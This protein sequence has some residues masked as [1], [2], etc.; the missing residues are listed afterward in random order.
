VGGRQLQQKNFVQRLKHL[1]AAHPSVPPSWLE[2]E[3]L[4]TSALEDIAQV[5]HVIESCRDIGVA[6]SIDDFGTGYSS[7][8]Y[9]RRLPVSLLKIDQSFVRD[10]LDDPDDL[11][12]LQGVIGLAKAFRRK[13]IAEGV[14]TAEHGSMLL[15]MGCE[16][17]Q[18]YGIARP[19]PG[20]DI[21]AW[22]KT[23]QPDPAWTHQLQVSGAESTLLFAG[24]EHRAW[25][26][27]MQRYLEGECEQPRELNQAQCRFA[28]WLATDGKAQYGGTPALAQLEALHQKIHVLAKQQHAL[29]IQG[30]QPLAPE[31]L[32]ELDMLR[33]SL[34]ELLQTL[35][36]HQP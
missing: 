2:L 28:A 17:A 13:V 15:Q 32:A 29:K 22:S 11:T 18:G 21:P 33:D 19:M 7:L 34:I 5:I 24:V 31:K 12:I 10:M 1:L 35:H 16:L 27:A 20:V 9:L 30:Q 26:K 36:E 8:T 23:W 4:E 6:F 25:V 3:V 14:E